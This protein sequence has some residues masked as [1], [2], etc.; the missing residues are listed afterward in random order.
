MTAAEQKT[1]SNQL[2]L[3]SKQPLRLSTRL[4]PWTCISDT[5]VKT[6]APEIKTLAP[7]VLTRP[8][9]QSSVGRGLLE[10]HAQSIATGWLHDREDCTMCHRG[11]MHMLGGQLWSCAQSHFDCARSIAATEAVACHDSQL[12]PASKHQQ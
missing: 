11:H 1:E 5:T 2:S 3:N 10:L 4:V 6:E 7:A 8:R 12:V 9:Q